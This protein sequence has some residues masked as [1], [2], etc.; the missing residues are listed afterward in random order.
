MDCFKSQLKP[1][2]TLEVRMRKPETLRKAME[3]AEE[4][5]SLSFSGQRTRTSWA[6][7]PS[8]RNSSYQ[9]VQAAW[10]PQASYSGPMAMEV[11][12]MAMHGGGRN[13]MGGGQRQFRRAQRA[14]RQ[15]MAEGIACSFCK[16]PAGK[17]AHWAALRADLAVGVPV[18]QDMQARPPP[19]MQSPGGMPALRQTAV[20][21]RAD[22]PERRGLCL[23]PAAKKG[24][25][26]PPPA[27]PIQLSRRTREENLEQGLHAPVSDA[28]QG[29][30]SLSQNTTDGGQASRN[31]AAQAD[32]AETSHRNNHAAVPGDALATAHAMAQA[33]AI[34]QAEQP[35]HHADEIQQ[36]LVLPGFLDRCPA[37]LLLDSGAA[38]NLMNPVT[39]ERLQIKSRKSPLSMWSWQTV[40]RVPAR[41]KG[42]LPVTGEGSSMHILVP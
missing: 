15:F 1:R 23:R 39:A 3:I 21:A 37:G 29:T 41:S 10:A 32:P 42:T 5:D 18:N 22:Q 20:Q 27:A 36:P 30:R 34:A 17:R 4:F 9:P 19:Q 40:L 12:A 13:Q 2:V 6:T 16:R 33:A 38:A 11:G 35:V 24:N 8:R 7:A 26:L 28:H 31:G 25:L 14:Q